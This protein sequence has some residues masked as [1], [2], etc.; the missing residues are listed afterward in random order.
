MFGFGF[1]TAAVRRLATA[2]DSMAQTAEETNMRW[3]E[4][5]A[6][7]KPPVEIAALEAP[8][9]PCHLAQ[10]ATSSPETGNTATVK[11]GRRRAAA[12]T[13]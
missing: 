8:A 7:D 9:G 11:N 2:F 5:L 4:Q 6:L 13:E 1:L 3:R 12:A 10:D